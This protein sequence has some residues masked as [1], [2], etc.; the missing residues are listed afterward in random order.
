M[1]QIM[2]SE[3]KKRRIQRA[4]KGFSLLPWRECF[5]S[6]GM[7][8]W[9]DAALAVLPVI[10]AHANREGEA[11][12]SYDTIRTL[13]RVSKTTVFAA[14]TELVETGRLVKTKQQGNNTYNRYRL[15]FG[16]Y[17]DDPHY[18][19]AIHHDLIF[20]GAWGAMRP[21]ER[22]VYLIFKAFA[23]KG[24]QAVPYGYQESDYKGPSAKKLELLLVN[25]AGKLREFD[26]SE[27]L[28]LP[29]HMYD[30]AEFRELSG[31]AP[32]TYSEA[33]GWLTENGLICPYEATGD[34]Q[35]GFIIPFQPGGKFPCVLEAVERVKR[36]NAKR[37]G[38]PGA[39]RSMNALLRR[40]ALGKTTGN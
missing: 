16:N 18:H 15:C 13:A 31:V 19:I 23:W 3:E 9:S 21:S 12:P 27:V 26:H 17:N 24:R 6:G 35:D 14:L 25:V 30:P 36:E 5:R 34:V 20:S 29:E 11:W 2:N 8:E 37:R 33:L 32:R 28:F 39:R 40:T 38:S 7:S 4:G 1:E 22:R 10:A